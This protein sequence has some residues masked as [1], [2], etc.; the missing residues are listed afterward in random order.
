[1]LPHHASDVQNDRTDALLHRATLITR[2]GHDF[3]DIPGLAL[4]EW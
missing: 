1:M 2:I 4:L 3:G